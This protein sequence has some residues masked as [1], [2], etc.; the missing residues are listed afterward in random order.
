M[1]LK[2]GKN[3]FYLEDN[4]VEIAEMTY[5]VAGEKMIIIDHTHVEETYKGQ[6]LGR[7]LLDEVVAF[8]RKEEKKIIPLCPYAKAQFEKDESIRDVLKDQ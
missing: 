4:E 1:N 8:A 2:Q 3:R 6:S 5:S 7:K